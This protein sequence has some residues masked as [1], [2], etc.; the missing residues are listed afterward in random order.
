MEFSIRNDLNTSRGNSKEIE[1][2]PSNFIL[3]NQ[4][5]NMNKTSFLIKNNTKKQISYDIKTISNNYSFIPSS[6]ILNPFHHHKIQ[7]IFSSYK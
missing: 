2:E 5:E 6:G 7:G 1:L 4:L 3:F